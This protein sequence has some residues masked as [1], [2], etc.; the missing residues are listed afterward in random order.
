[1]RTKKK[2]KS[3]RIEISDEFYLQS[4]A[5]V[6]QAKNALVEAKKNPKKVVFLKKGTSYQWMKFKNRI[7]ENKSKY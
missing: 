5:R 1:M 3:L 2:T 7:N 4:V 6:E